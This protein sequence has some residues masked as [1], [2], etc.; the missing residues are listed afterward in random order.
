MS[1]LHRSSSPYSTQVWA[2]VRYRAH[3]GLHVKLT[4][5]AQLDTVHADRQAYM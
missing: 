5:Y 4:I 2:A 1:P 3:G